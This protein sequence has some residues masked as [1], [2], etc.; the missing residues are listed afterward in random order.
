MTPEEVKKYY[1]STY[2]FRKDTGMSCSS[3]VNWLKWGRVPLLSQLKLEK[4]T[5]GELRADWK[6]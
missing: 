1:K 5:Q 3:L 6:T 4:M 2:G